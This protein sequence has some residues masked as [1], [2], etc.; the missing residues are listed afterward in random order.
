M[1]YDRKRGHAELDLNRTVLALEC[2]SVSKGTNIKHSV[3]W[4][5]FHIPI[6]N[7]TKDVHFM[8]CSQ[9]LWTKHS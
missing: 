5:M 2:L 6:F 7:K 8:I 9:L 4:H 3:I 1:I